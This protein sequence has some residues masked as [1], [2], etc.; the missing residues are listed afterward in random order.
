MLHDKTAFHSQTRGMH[1]ILLNIPHLLLLN[2]LIERVGARPLASLS[3][4]NGG[5]GRKKE[6]SP[7]QQWI[8][9]SKRKK[10]GKLSPMKTVNRGPQF[11]LDHKIIQW[12]RLINL[13]F[14]LLSNTW[15]PSLL[16]LHKIL[17]TLPPR[18]TPS[19]TLEN[20]IEG[21]SEHL[22]SSWT[23]TWQACTKDS[24]VSVAGTRLR[25]KSTEEETPLGPGWRFEHPQKTEVGAGVTKKMRQTAHSSLGDTIIS[26]HY[27]F[28][29]D[30]CVCVRITDLLLDHKNRMIL[31]FKKKRKKKE[32]AAYKGKSICSGMGWGKKDFT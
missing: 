27:K 32:K 5:R 10:E 31:S 1:T 8:N 18:H 26:Q 15:P 28:L 17:T 24:G 3:L 7:K 20:K 2:W 9:L 4:E 25:W 13:T 19:N 11:F 29:L 14:L 12:A 30:L 22:Q 21:L 6:S 16:S 23:K